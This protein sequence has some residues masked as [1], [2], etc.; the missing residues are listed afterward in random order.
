MQP[1]A[2]AARAHER[3]DERDLEFGA[4][5]SPPCFMHELDPGFLGVSPDPHPRSAL[6]P[7]VRDAVQPAPRPE[8]PAEPERDRTR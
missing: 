4:Y 8:A 6:R 2:Q 3:P 1:K 5:S 7:Q